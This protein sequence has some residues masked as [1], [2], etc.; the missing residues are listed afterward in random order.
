ML[1]TIFTR[2]S[3][4][5]AAV[6]QKTGISMRISSRSELFQ[7]KLTPNLRTFLNRFLEV[8]LHDSTPLLYVLV[9]DIK[10]IQS[11]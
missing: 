5:T 9:D 10:I 8:P 3:T 11:S 6:S 4:F 7:G 1:P 2:L